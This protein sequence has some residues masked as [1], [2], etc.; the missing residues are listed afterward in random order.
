MVAFTCTVGSR[1]IK[2]VVKERQEAKKAFDDAVNRGE[3][4]GLLETSKEAS[5]VFT[6]TI[7]NVPAGE[8][9]KVEITYL[10]E[11]KHDAEVD[12]LR[13]TIPTSI[14]PR[15]GDR[16]IDTRSHIPQ[17]ET[18]ISL[19][20]DADMT[21]GSA[22]KS[23]QS[24]SHPISVNIGT[25]STAS[26][27]TPSLERASASL[28]LGATSLDKDFILQIVANGIGDPA[29][30][31]ETH[32]TKPNQRALMATLVPRFNLPVDRPEVVFVCD[33]SGSMSQGNKIPNIIGALQIFL[34]SLP[35]GIKFN[36]CSFGSRFSFLWENSQTYNEETLN[37]A[38]EHVKRFAADF[39]G[40]E[41][42][43]PMQETFQRRYKDSNLEVF[44]LTDGEI[45]DQDNLFQLINSEVS[46]T[47][48][49]VRVFTLGVGD[50]V[51]HALIEGVARAGNGFSQTVA[52]NE[53]MDKKIVRMLKGALT[54][55]VRDYRLEIKYEQ[56]ERR[57]GGNGGDDDDFEFVEKVMDSLTIDVKDQPQE[58]KSE[59]QTTAEAKKPISLFDPSVKDED[60][61]MPSATD[62]PK[63]KLP[64]I[65]TPRYLQTPFEIPPLFSFN[66]TTVYVLLSDSTPDRKPKSVVLKG[67]SLHG[68]LELEIPVTTLA[69]KGTTIHQLA[70]RKAVGELEEGRGWI[71]H[72]KEVG[73][74][75]LKDKFA[76]RFSDIV[77]QEAVK[78]GVEYQIGGKW[79]SFVAVQEGSGESLSK[80]ETEG[81]Q[82]DDVGD[83][84]VVEAC[85]IAPPPMNPFG[86]RAVMRTAMMR[87]GGGPP[88]HSIMSMSLMS[89]PAPPPPAAQPIG[90]FSLAS[91][92]G[93]QDGNP[94]GS[95]S[96]AAP[97]S[98]GSPATT[99]GFGSAA[100][101]R[102]F[103]VNSQPEAVDLTKHRMPGSSTTS[104]L[105]AKKKSAP[106]ASRE[107]ADMLDNDDDAGSDQPISA[108]AS[109]QN[110]AGSWQWTPRLE[111]VIGITKA[112]ALRLNLPTQYDKHD[113]ILATLCAVV[114]LKK[115]QAQEK[116]TWELFVEKAESW[117]ADATG[118]SPESL[119]NLVEKELF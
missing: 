10:G 45:W 112:T 103:N 69:D 104:G 19:T 36:I 26:S 3:T 70:A 50:D 12:G 62:L 105:K 74:Q 18:A 71:V 94:F 56:E 58:P 64:P 101:S 110:F 6:T 42:Y 16:G 97:I 1:V 78:L 54:P 88:Q 106:K 100:A 111:K 22:I 57:I 80:D 82:P 92:S 32:S 66:R 20:I 87:G 24:P 44:L 63:V 14:A 8:K 53:K 48:G 28:S 89:A 61:E 109:L 77:K 73:G 84:E 46:K 115:K 17:G 85:D 4:A 83:F 75:L 15:Y 23:I 108:L 72:A 37:E 102:S 86:G 30:I 40:T 11:L 41:M 47:E 34:K 51:S 52:E 79:C 118:T 114:F 21:A 91:A 33:R 25:T 59:G 29:A 107:S 93:G 96:P 9:I 119:Q 117:L 43:Q 7:G 95:G 13:F 55:H 67:T 60:L 2:G 49:S 35:V 38:I 76:S 90:G 31:L 81:G 39:G 65:A 5:D 27:A 113:E 116:D 68:P 98:F 99:M